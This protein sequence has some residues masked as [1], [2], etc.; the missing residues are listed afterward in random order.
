MKAERIKGEREGYFTDNFIA[1]YL[2]TPFPKNPN[3]MHE[4]LPTFPPLS[5]K[6]Q[7]QC[8]NCFLPF[9]PFSQRKGVKNHNCKNPHIRIDQGFSNHVMQCTSQHT[10]VKH[11]SSTSMYPVMKV[12]CL[13]TMSIYKQ[14]L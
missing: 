14:W 13:L 8:M 2:S 10:L 1:S 7:T 5:Q 3:S 9:Q 11:S 6:I 4:L 12:V